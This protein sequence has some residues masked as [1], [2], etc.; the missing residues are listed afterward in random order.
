MA[1]L[2]PARRAVRLL[3][4]GVPLAVLPA[5]VPAGLGPWA[6][7]AW[8]AWMGLSLLGVVMDALLGLPGRRLAVEAAS[9]GTV[10]L[11]ET[12]A[13]ALTLSASGWPR[14]LAVEV[15]CELGA[16]FLPQPP[17][18]TAIGAG[19]PA[20]VRV[21][22]VPSRRGRG[23]IAAVWL[24]WTGPFGLMERIDR[25]ELGREVAVVPGLRAVRS[26]ALRFFSRRD[27][28]A[29]LKVERYVGEGS[30]FESLKEYAPGFD[31]R[32]LDWKASARHRK[33]LCREYRAERNHQVILAFD[34]GHLMSEPLAGLPRLDHAIHAGLLLAYVSLKAEDRVGACAFDERVRLF[35]EPAGGVRSFRLLQQQTARLSYSSAETNFTLGLLELGR[36]LK[37]RSLV[38]ALTDFVD[39]MTAELML[40]NLGRLARRHLVLF[41]SLR[42]PAV[43]QVADA[44]PG[45]VDDLNRAMTA[46]DLLREREVVLSRL[47]RLGIH[48]I[49]ASPREVS[50]R[51]INSY[52]D[53]KRREQV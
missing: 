36:R 23:R 14:E 52:L 40:D 51:L 22:L 6:A 21:P 17:A 33:L 7:T 42:D 16:P 18:T 5:I 24:R 39:T 12:A 34:T 2:R 38:V 20:R 37:R 19:E 9:P 8:A 48:V 45:S 46:R 50:T 3:G 13:C 43:H 53:I 32:S 44:P 28:A 11:G 15:L 1:T 25:R 27:L 31:T 47:R 10:Q 29:G 35:I 4:A 30:E 26:A 41:V 49:E